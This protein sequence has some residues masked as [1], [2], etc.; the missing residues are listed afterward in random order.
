MQV[1]WRKLTSYVNDK[2][3]KSEGQIQYMALNTML[4]FVWNDNVFKSQSDVFTLS[5]ALWIC[6]INALIVFKCC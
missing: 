3:G 1:F 5:I 4:H 6:A 2:Q